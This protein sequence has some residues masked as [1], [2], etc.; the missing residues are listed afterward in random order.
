[1]AGPKKTDHDIHVELFLGGWITTY[2]FTRN[3]MKTSISTL[4]QFLKHGGANYF[5]LEIAYWPKTSYPWQ[6]K[7]FA[8]LSNNFLNIHLIGEKISCHWMIRV[9]PKK[10]NSQACTCTWLCR[11]IQKALHILILTFKPFVKH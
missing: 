6:H 7:D 10:N 8:N 2:T 3:T 4:T 9:S 1:M 11:A 5:F